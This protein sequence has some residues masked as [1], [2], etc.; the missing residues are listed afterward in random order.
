MSAGMGLR[1]TNRVM[2][3]LVLL[4]VALILLFCAIVL[5]TQPTQV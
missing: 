4:A 2:A 1:S 5:S 3:F